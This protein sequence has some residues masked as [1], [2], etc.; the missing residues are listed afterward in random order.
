LDKGEKGGG[1]QTYEIYNMKNSQIAKTYK[2]LSQGRH[3]L[4]KVFFQVFYSSP[5]QIYHATDE[6]FKS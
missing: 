3:L 1:V 4:G 2:P 6:G 5:C